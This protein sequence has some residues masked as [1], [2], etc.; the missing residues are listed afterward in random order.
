MTTLPKKRE[1]LFQSK[2]EN[3]A[4]GMDYCAIAIPQTITKSLGTPN[5]RV[6]GFGYYVKLTLILQSATLIFYKQK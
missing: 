2:L 4:E 3:W 1:L 6:G 5:A